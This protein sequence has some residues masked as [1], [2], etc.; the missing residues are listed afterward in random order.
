MLHKLIW[1][2]LCRF[3]AADSLYELPQRRQ[4]LRA[5]AFSDVEPVAYFF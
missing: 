5:T 3:G 2:N 1:F 4:N